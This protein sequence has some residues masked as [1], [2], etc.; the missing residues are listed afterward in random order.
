MKTIAI[1]LCVFWLSFFAL[2]QIPQKIS[3]QGVITGVP[4]GSYTLKFDMY[5][6]PAGGVLSHTETFTGVSVSQGSFNV[7]LGSTAVLP[8]IFGESLFVEI[9]ATA[10]P[11]GPGYPLVFSP[12]S[13]LTSSPY[14]LAPWIQNGNDIYYSL[15]KVGIGGTP[16]GS[17]LLQVN[18][19]VD[20]GGFSINGTPIGTSSSSYWSL[21]SGGSIYYN[22]GAVCI[23]TTSP[24]G[25]L[26][27]EGSGIALSRSG[28]G[29]PFTLSKDGN[30]PFA[31][32]E[33]GTANQY[34][35][36][37]NSS[38]SVGIGTI[39]PLTS[40]HVEGSG[41]TLSRSGFGNPFTLS[42]DGNAPFAIFEAGTANQYRLVVKSNGN[43]GIGTTSPDAP[44]YV[45][46]GL[47][48]GGNGLPA[49]LHVVNPH[50][51]S[52]PG[53]YV[54]QPGA[55]DF[56]QIRL[57]VTG[58]P[59]WLMATGDSPTPSLQFSSSLYTNVLVLGSD[60]TVSVP[61]LQ[62]NGAD[63]AEPFELS[64]KDIPKGSVVVIDEDEPGKLKLTNQP[65]D[66]RV[67]G[68]LSGANGVTSGICLKQKGFNDRGQ[69]VALSG[70]VFALADASNG[71][72]KPGDLL[73]TSPTPGH[74]MKVTDHTRAQGAIIGKAM[75]SLKE[76]KGMV[77]VLVSLQ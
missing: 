1:G 27:V 24:M 43:V 37:I 77:L 66:V 46:G 34:R 13:A 65:Y 29:N 6:L 69:N 41:I 16:T 23:G 32:F 3:Y 11:P 40:L 28:Y 48:D 72:I 56:A 26:H 54:E 20:A 76:G 30:A 10:G 62:I 31:L 57:N 18:G 71:S 9:T 49:A 75:S 2:A 52:Q 73:T 70:R 15:G 50:G 61:V 42:K 63:I 14:S 7:I 35:L 38:G 33:A 59:Y 67:A 36:V 12:R 21:G 74:C 58:R 55:G 25:S 45:N 68:I 60:G 17:S 39:S 53:I 47:V 22:S 51:Y 8:P 19:N 5:T 4:D 64:T 44:L